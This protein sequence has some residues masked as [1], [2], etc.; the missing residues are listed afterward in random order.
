MSTRRNLAVFAATGAATGLLLLYPT[1]TSSRGHRR[2]GT[3][4]APAGV[5]R[6]T[7]TAHPSTEL[8][9]NGQAADT[10]YGPVQVQLVLRAGRIVRAV[11]I[12]YPQGSG[13]D[14]EI[15]AYAIPVLQRETLA[16]QSAR[17]DM[18]SGATYT[19][20]GYLRSLQSAL[21]EAGPRAPR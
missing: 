1:S 3:A 21:D 10:A 12:D 15:N 13:R 5:V 19:S 4:A 16:A 6:P 14:Q 11:A 9:V 18:V 8:V 7:A 20:D 2:P 17:I